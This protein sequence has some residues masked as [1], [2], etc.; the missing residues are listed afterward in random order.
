LSVYEKGMSPHATG[1]GHFP[2]TPCTRERIRIVIERIAG[3]I[4]LKLKARAGSR[5]IA[6]HQKKPVGLRSERLG[7]F[8]QAMTV[9]ISVQRLLENNLLQVVALPLLSGSAIF[10]SQRRGAVRSC[11]SQAGPTIMTRFHG[12]GSSRSRARSLARSPP[13]A[14]TP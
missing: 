12:E 4:A 7:G 1:T 11:A 14:L 5:D 8:D 10:R 2:R 3:Q 6:K 9:G 13:W